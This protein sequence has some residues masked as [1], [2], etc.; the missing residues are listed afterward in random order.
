MKIAVLISGLARFPEQGFTFLERIINHSSHDIDVFAGVWSIDEIPL[1]VSS[2]LKKVEVIPYNLRN[3]L[4]FLLENNHL[5]N[6]QL[7]L[8]LITENHALLIA[9]MAACSAFKDDLINYDL[10]VKWR[11]DVAMQPEDFEIIC[12]KHSRENQWFI[13]DDIYMYRGNFIMNDVVFSARSDIMLKTFLPLEE[14]FLELGRMLQQDAIKFGDKLEL[15]VLT[16]LPKLISNS[17]G[18]I[19][20]VPFRWAL[21]RKNILDNPEYVNCRDTKW[22]IKLQQ[23]HDKLRDKNKY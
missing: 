1:S 11:W 23:E 22:L 13:T 10:I 9:H 21:L 17:L 3:E 14:K 20:A 2:K 18:S 16:S 19:V 8:N 5:T 15:S 12:N 6:K 4:Y 7:S